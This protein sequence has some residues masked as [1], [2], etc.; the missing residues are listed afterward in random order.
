MPLD[1]PE[2]VLVVDDVVWLDRS[3]LWRCRR[4]S[5]VVGDRQAG[6]EGG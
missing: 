3:L 2:E 4:P 6:L 5:A 1:Q